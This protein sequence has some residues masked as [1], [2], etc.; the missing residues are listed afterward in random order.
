M[1]QPNADRVLRDLGRKIAEL[2]HA[3]GLTQAGLAERSGIDAKYLQLL[4]GGRQNTTIATL[5]CIAQALRATLSELLEPPTARPPRR[6]GRP[7]TE[8]P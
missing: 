3:R 4:E 5:V 2:R 7:R 6:P 8:R 1:R